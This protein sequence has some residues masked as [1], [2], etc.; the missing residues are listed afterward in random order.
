MYPKPS[1]KIQCRPIAA[2]DLAAIAA[3]LVKGFP[4][5]SNEFWLAGLRR[6]GE[7]SVPEGLPHY[8]YLLA[9]GNRVV[10]ALILIVSRRRSESGEA[11]FANV[12]GWYVEPEFR[13]YAPFLVSVALRHRSVTYLNVSPAPHTWPMVE[14]Q[15]YKLY[16]SGLFVAFAGLSAWVRG[17]RLR[18]FDRLG[19]RDLPEHAMLARHAE[20]GCTV[21]V[22]EHQ[23]ASHP[24]VFKPFRIR[25]GRWWTPCAL[26]IYARSQAELVKF[27]GP[28]GRRLLWHGLPL[29]AMDGDGPVAGLR[30]V[31]TP[32]HGRRYFRG[33]NRPKLCDLTD[34]EFVLFGI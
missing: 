26:A 29:I 34:T 7:R 30:G 4:G 27:A 8:G 33:A 5:R 25:S 9:A 10:G 31:Y 2:D 16:S 18:S 19:D 3:L 12:A 20:L 15:G 22:A 17:A 28:L 14:S 13:G 24:F 21:I 32:R 6:L 1:P 23:G 11:L